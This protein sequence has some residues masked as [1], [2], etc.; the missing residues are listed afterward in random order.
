M[1]HVESIVECLHGD[2]VFIQPH[3]FPDADAIASAYGMKILLAKYGVR[4]TIVYKRRQENYCIEKILNEFKVHLT[5]MMDEVDTMLP[6]SSEI[7]LVDSQVGNTN[8]SDIGGRYV[9]CIDHHNMPTELPKYDYY[10]IRPEVGACSTIIAEYFLEESVPFHKKTATL[11]TYGIRTDTANLCRGVSRNDIDM[12]GNLFEIADYNLIK[13][14]ENS[15]IQYVDIPSYALALKETEIYNNISFTYVGDN[16]SDIILSQICDFMLSV[17]EIE[18]AITCSIRKGGIKLSVR[19]IKKKCDAGYLTHRVLRG[20]GDGGGH[21]TMAGGFVPI[22]DGTDPY[23][24]M[25]EVKR[26]FIDIT[27]KFVK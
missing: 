8:V 10:D 18:I 6:A 19:S 13:L 4:A 2:R 27:R 24:L 1:T 15:M 11:L 5:E 3:D 14:L 20:I 25:D 12:L 26:R 17:V 23:A 16:C 21:P 9:A 22:N 7:I